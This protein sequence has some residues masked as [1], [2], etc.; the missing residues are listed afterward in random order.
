MT[1]K[2]S[3]EKKEGNEGTL[4]FEVDADSFNT[5]LDKAFRKVVKKVNVPGFR[6]GHVPRILFEQRFGVEALY[7]DAVDFVLPNAYTEAID[8]TGIEPVDRPKVDV[9]EIGKG[10]K[11]VLTADVMVKPEV[12]LGAY[13]GLE[14]E[15]KSTEVTD[16]DVDH[17]IKHLQERYAELVVKNDGQVEKGDTVV[18]DFDGYVDGKQFEGGKADNYSLEIGSGSFIPGFEDQLIGL[19]VNEE[20]DVVV[21]FPKDYHAEDLKGKEATFKV[22][23]H[24]IKRKQLPAL[25]DEFAKDTDEDVE[26]FDALKEK[27]RARLIEQKEA[28]AKSSKRESVVEQASANAEIDIPEVMVSNEQDNMVKEF[29]QRLQ[30]Q[31]LNL[32]TYSKLTGTDQ[33]ALRDQMKDD[34]EKRVRT[35]LT[36]EAVAD[37]EKIEVSEDEI[38]EELKKMAETYKIK[39][40]QLK[41]ALGSTKL[42]EGDLRLRKALDFLV[43]NSKPKTEEKPSE[44]TDSEKKEKAAEDK[45]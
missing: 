3:W 33:S 18:L 11:L 45:K 20:K 44:K 22:K 2:A 35:N 34:A 37:A 41:K 28:D 36:L 5:A 43:D 40:D 15:Q 24:E 7:E 27:V 14:V 9:K 26:T 16:A 1:V 42:V 19:K 21:T 13:K 23:I 31:G 38:N 10:K 8:Q 12:K 25:D 30:Q 4:T 39:V 17:E 32:E 6:K 29:S